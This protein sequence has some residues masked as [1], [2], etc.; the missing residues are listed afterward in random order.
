[1]VL[2]RMQTVEP[3]L[4][5]SAFVSSTTPF[6]SGTDDREH[7]IAGLRRAG[8]PEGLIGDPPLTRRPTGVV[9]RLNPPPPYQLLSQTG[10]WDCFARG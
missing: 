6:Q 3:D 10:A 4:T 8:V 9:P 5:V 1:M 2:R 7:V